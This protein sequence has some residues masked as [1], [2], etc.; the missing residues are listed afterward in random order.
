MAAIRIRFLTL[1]VLTTLAASAYAAT[2]VRLI[3]DTDIGN[4]IDDALALAMI[5]AME[6]RGEAK[7]L[8]VTITKDTPFT[9]PFVDLVDTFY[10]RPAIPIGTVR[11]GKT[12]DL[13]PYCRPVVE[14]G[15]YPHTLNDGQSAPEAVSVLRR[16]LAAEKDHSV[17]IVQVGF[18]TNLA[19]LL[20]SPADQYSMLSGLELVR[21]KVHLIVAMAGS[22]PAGPKPE[23]NVV[24]DI[25]SARTL[26]AE[27][28]V[29]IVFSGFEL[30]LR[31]LYP[32][33]SI[34]K[35]FSFVPHH[36][37]ADAYRD[38]MKMP[39]DRPTWD[40]TAVLYAVRPKHSFRLSNPGKVTVDE[41]GATLFTEQKN[42][43]DRYLLAS[44]A[45]ETTA[46]QQMIELASQ[47]VKLVRKNHG[48]FT[49]GK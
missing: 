43:P 24:T 46:R 22:F 38:F 40:L 26:F 14:S 6:S 37:I 13:D 8:A 35:D 15:L 31:I 33:S 12:K 4:D 27:S 21:R 20:H 5:H 23:Y 7:L 41:K 39:Y 45:Q 48:G 44:P 30:G 36:P 47:P 29:P 16:I 17:T 34:E 10:N 11:N 18:S 25:D 28:P 19:R 3:F 32:A 49:N 1:V 42:G 9:G 2:P